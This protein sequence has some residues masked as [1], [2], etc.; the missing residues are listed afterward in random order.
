MGHTLVAVF[1]EG[2]SRK[3]RELLKEAGTEDAC[4]IPFGRGCDRVTTDRV[5]KHHI[6]LYNWAKEEDDV[7]LKRLR[8]LQ[9]IPPCRIIAI[10]PVIKDG[11]SES[12]LVCLEVV[13]SKEFSK[14][15]LIVGQLLKKTPNKDLHITLDA[16]KDASRAKHLYECLRNMKCFPL[17]LNISG[18]ELYEIWRPTKL[19]KNYPISR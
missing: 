18:L 19:V 11:K 2:S 17:E 16:T 13:A 1:A 6:T 12:H 14:M 8:S 3:L 10:K 9:S 15:S 4:K 5:L 7:Y